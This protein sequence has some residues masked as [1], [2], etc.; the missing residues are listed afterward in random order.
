MLWGMSSWF[1]HVTVVP[2]FTFSGIGEKVKLSMTTCASAATAMLLPITQRHMR[3]HHNRCACQQIAGCRPLPEG[4]AHILQRVSAV[5]EP[6]SRRGP[7]QRRCRIGPVIQA[8]EVATAPCF[9]RSA[10]FMDD[11]ATVQNEQR[12]YVTRSDGGTWLFVPDPNVPTAKPE[13]QSAKRR[14]W[15]SAGLSLLVGSGRFLPS[16][17]PSPRL[18]A[19]GRLALLCPVGAAAQKIPQD[20]VLIDGQHIGLCQ[21]AAFGQQEA[22]VLLESPL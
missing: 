20:C 15:P 10:S 14:G 17:S 18:I 8:L 4:L 16:L 7:V 19:P 13:T 22:G 9:G 12:V 5:W 1:T 2:V 11:S 21:L 6:G 3:H